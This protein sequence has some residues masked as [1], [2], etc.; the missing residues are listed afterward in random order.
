ME[1]ALP[2]A[3]MGEM[4]CSLGYFT[5]FRYCSL[6]VSSPILGGNKIAQMKRTL[7]L[8]LAALTTHFMHSQSVGIGTTTPNAR[9][10][11]DINSTTKGLLIP[12]MTTSQ[13]LAIASPPNGLMVYDTERNSFYHYTGSTWSAILNGDYWIRP[14][15]TRSRISNPDDS[16]G[17]GTNLPSERLD[18]NGNIRSRND[19]LVDGGVTANSDLVINN[20]NAILQL[21]SSGENKGYYQLSGDNVR[22]GTNSGNTTGNLIIRMNGNDRVTVTPNGNMDLDGKITR[23]AVTGNAPLLPVCMGQVSSGG[24]IINGTGN[25]TV[26]RSSTAWY[27]LSCPLFTSTSIILVTPLT[28]V[29]RFIGAFDTPGKIAV[30]ASADFPFQ[31]VVYNLN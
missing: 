1:R 14:S 28:G 12:S 26:V 27:E 6:L 10:A 20:T 31:F 2:I 30:V 21:R 22:M 5:L 15:A 19:I 23:T 17:I 13:R 7:F 29:D 8:L 16:V 9:A 25:F 3:K 11:L 18:V 24:N 4:N